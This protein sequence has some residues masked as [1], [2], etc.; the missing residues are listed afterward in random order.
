MTDITRKPS[1]AEDRSTDTTPTPAECSHSRN[2]V[3]TVSRSTIRRQ[4]RAN[5]ERRA[6]AEQQAELLRAELSPT[7]DRRRF[8]RPISPMRARALLKAADELEHDET[9][10]LDGNFGLPTSIVRSQPKMASPW[11]YIMRHGFMRLANPITGEVIFS[12]EI[13]A[14]QAMD[15]YP[16]L[17]FSYL[18]E[19]QNNTTTIRRPIVAED[20]YNTEQKAA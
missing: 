19:Q 6:E 2:A 18:E 20:H 8:G 1:A 5:A 3:R 12:G 14:G 9:S 17:L 13:P 16:E 7:V 10:K 15:V 4:R 11:G